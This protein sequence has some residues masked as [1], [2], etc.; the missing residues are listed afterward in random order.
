MNKKIY[1]KN[2]VREFEE[3]EYMVLCNF[4]LNFTTNRAPV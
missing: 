4:L 3:F 1:I 2:T